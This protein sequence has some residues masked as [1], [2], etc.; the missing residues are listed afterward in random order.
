[1]KK[2]C[3]NNGLCL[4]NQNGY[5]CICTTQN[6][7]GVNCERKHSCEKGWDPLA[8][9][10]TQMCATVSTK[11]DNFNGQRNKCSGKTGVLPVPVSSNDNEV[12]QKYSKQK[13]GMG[14]FW[15][16]LFCHGDGTWKSLDQQ[17]LVYTNFEN[18]EVNHNS[19]GKSDKRVR[20]HKEVKFKFLSGGYES[21][22]GKVANFTSQSLEK[23]GVFER[24]YPARN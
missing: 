12:L 8:F 2:P 6:S 22:F 11:G 1:M 16:G 23:F 19:C 7:F 13:K 5:S 21:R 17:D 15:L 4:N 9:Q 3:E 14:A 18:Q 20:N 24:R 10:A